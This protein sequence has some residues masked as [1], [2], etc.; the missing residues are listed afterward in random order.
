MQ[1]PFLNKRN[2]AILNKAKYSTKRRTQE[3]NNASE[4]KPQVLPLLQHE[5]RLPKTG[6]LPISA[7]PVWRVPVWQAVQKSD[8]H[9]AA[10][11]HHA[12]APGDADAD[13]DADGDASAAQAAHV[14]DAA[15]REAGREESADWRAAAPQDSSGGAAPGEEDHRN[16]A[17]AGQRRAVGAAVGSAR[18]D[19]QDQRGPG[20]AQGPSAETGGQVM[21]DLARNPGG[22]RYVNITTMM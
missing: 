7:S 17:R 8:V 4:Q 21:T 2:K 5:E 3:Q 22:V 14:R 13:A 10:S 11:A 1:I 6:K 16:A 20:G 15:G 19:K 12:P 18:V 9:A